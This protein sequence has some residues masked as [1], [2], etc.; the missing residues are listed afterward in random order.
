MGLGKHSPHLGQSRLG[1]GKNCSLGWEGE[2][3][4]DEAGGG[5]VPWSSCWARFRG[6]GRRSELQDTRPLLPGP[7]FTAFVS[8]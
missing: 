1:E 2:A 8:S 4:C 5:T 3:L 7:P 6:E